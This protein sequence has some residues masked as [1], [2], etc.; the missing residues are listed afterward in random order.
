MDAIGINPLDERIY[1]ALLERPGSDEY[2][3][4]EASGIDPRW[5]RGSLAALEVKGLASRLPGSPSRF[6]PTPPDIGME[7][8][9]LHQ[10][11]ELEKL[12]LR[13]LEL[14]DVYR[15]STDTS[16]V[17][18]LI[19]ILRGRETIAQRVEH[20]Q[21]TAKDEMM[22]FDCP[23]YLNGRP[24]VEAEVELLQKGIRFRTMYDHRALEFGEGMGIRAIEKL[25]VAGE[26]ARSLPEL[27][28]KLAIADH[29]LAL[30]P[31]AATTPAVETAVLVHPCALLDA[32]IMLFETL[33]ARA[34]PIRPGLAASGARARDA[35]VPDQ[36]RLLTLLGAG[37]SDTAVARELGVSLRTVTR[38][39]QT[40]S[41][42]AGA[43][44]R[45]Q[46][47]WQAGR[48]GWL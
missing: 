1:R 15:A 14:M 5:V 30:I 20:M 12:R 38:R 48:H 24:Q 25:V 28:M 13:M 26:E 47:G 3:L 31:L 7:I 45:F 37:M 35:L 22:F 39:I 29:K 9:V 6:L 41:S 33:W 43:A 8:L 18:R 4:A 23:P 32:L 16:D 11:Q 46:L 34:V 10:Q 21:C 44:T 42:A 19:E 2:S 27:P 36:E 17:D 40:L